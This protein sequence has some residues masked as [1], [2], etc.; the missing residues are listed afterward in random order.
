VTRPENGVFD[1]R[2]SARASS[3]F[4]PA[5]NKSGSLVSR[6]EFYYSKKGSNRAGR[7][8]RSA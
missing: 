3:V 1:S 2:G 6:M 7:H 4:N 5:G 8:K